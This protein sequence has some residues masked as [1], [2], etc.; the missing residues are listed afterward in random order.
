MSNSADESQPRNSSV[1]QKTQLPCYA[2]LK[3][4]N[5]HIMW[6]P[7]QLNHVVICF[8][9]CVCDVREIVFHFHECPPLHDVKHV[10]SWNF[11]EDKEKQ[12]VRLSD[13]GFLPVNF[14]KKNH[15]YFGS[16]DVPFFQPCLVLPVLRTTPFWFAS[17]PERCRRRV[18]RFPCTKFAGKKREAGLLAEL[19]PDLPGNWL[20][21]PLKAE[22]SAFSG[23][24]H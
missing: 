1:A 18:Y 19:H 3:G 22:N 16:I 7:S 4:R 12:H 6:P 21:D 2:G 23:L 24:C 14:P 20:L 13:C 15:R 9:S 8:L 11:G 17:L 5:V 10:W